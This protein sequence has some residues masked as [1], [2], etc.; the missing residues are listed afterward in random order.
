MAT[1]AGRMI[2][3]EAVD[4]SRIS[5]VEE[6]SG[7]VAWA[8]TDPTP[9]IWRTSGRDQNRVSSS[10]SVTPPT[11]AAYEVSAPNARPRILLT[12]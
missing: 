8:A 12:T 2:A 10:P 5:A 6:W 7:E 4:R 1:A 9:D 11:R 3:A